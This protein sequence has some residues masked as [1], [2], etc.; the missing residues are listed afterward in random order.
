M[1]IFR[2]WKIAVTF[3]TRSLK[4]QFERLINTFVIE[5]TNEEP[6]R[7]SIQIMHSWGSP[8]MPGIYYT[9]CRENGAKYFDFATARNA[10]ADGKEFQGACDHALAEISAPK[11]LFDAILI[12]E[13]QDLPSSFLRLCY[14]S[15]R[16]PH[17]LVYAYDELQSLTNASLPPP[18]E[19]FGEDRAGNPIVRFQDLGPGQPRQDIILE[20]CYRN[21]RPILAT[22]HA[23]GFGIY[24]EPGGLIQIFDQKHL[25]LDVGYRVTDGA[26]EDNTSV[27]LERTP[28]TSPRFL[29]EHSP[30]DDLIA[31][32]KFASREEQ[33]E[34]L[35]AE[36]QRN[37]KADGLLPEDIIVINPDPLKTR[38]AVAS[39]RAKL[40]ELGIN[41]NLA[42]VSSSPDVFFSNDTVTFTGIFRAKGNE[43]AM[44]YIINA[45]DC[46][47]S[48][49]PAFLTKARNQLFTALTRSKAWVRVL[50]VGKGMDGLIAEYERVKANGYA[51]KFIYP[52]EA[53]RQKLRVINR[54]M[55]RAEQSRVS[56]KV[57]EL[58]NVLA[59]I[60][61][62]QVRLEDLPIELRS[63]L[64]R[65][66]GK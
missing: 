23:L 24:R 21:S 11:A 60:D 48:F 58:A 64:E 39:S 53:T 3:N 28:D 46:F 30:V 9:F 45:D 47:D 25:W 42:G 34:W 41:S 31:F 36:I 5:Q 52:D 44:V 56:Q 27:S 6:D 40:F 50:G 14:N 65:L 2:Y 38:A 59:A 12:D 15:I 57:S 55:T 32:R 16:D 51:L 61:E 17:R 18:E 7:T 43:A 63:R 4:G 19:L 49:L 8:S 54:D 22:A 10:F 35:V 33:D 1:Q 26:L 66:V 13:A 62:G 20:R 37:I 29:E